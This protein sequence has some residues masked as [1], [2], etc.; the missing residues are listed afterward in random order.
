MATC[1]PRAKSSPSPLWQPS[2]K[3]RSPLE[4]RKAEIEG[5]LK[6]VNPNRMSTD[7]KAVME[8]IR[9]FQT[10]ADEAAKRGD[11]HSADAISE[12]ALIL[13]KELASGR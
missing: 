6:G 12:R 11:F 7:Q 1:P 10:V 2:R 4:R 9:S 13:A 3:W 5:L 8:R